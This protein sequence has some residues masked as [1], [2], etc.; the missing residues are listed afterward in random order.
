VQIKTLSIPDE[1]SFSLSA[2][3]GINTISTGKEFQTNQRFKSDYF[4]GETNSRTWFVGREAEQAAQSI[5]NAGNMNHYRF[6]KYTV[7]PLQNYA[8]SFGLPLQINPKHKIGLVA[9][10]TCRHEES[11]EDIKGINTIGLDTLTEN[12]GE[13]FNKNYKFVTSI[14]AIANIGWETANHSV[15]WRNLFNNRF[16]HSTLNRVMFKAY[17]MLD[18][19]LQLDIYTSPLQSRLLQT[20]IDGEHNLFRKQLKITWAADYNNISRI[21]PDDRFAQATIRSSSTMPD[22]NE[23]YII[24]WTDQLTTFMSSQ[25]VM[26]SR[27]NETKKNAGANA[28][29]TFTLLNN[30]QK[31]KAG[32]LHSERAADCEQ[33][34]LHAYIDAKHAQYPINSTSLVGFYDPDHFESGVPYYKFIGYNNRAIAY[35]KGNQSVDAFYIMGEFTPIAPLKIVGGVRLEDARTTVTTT[36]TGFNDNGS[37]FITKDSIV[38]RSAQDRLPSVTAIYSIT[39]ALNFRASYFESIAR[40]DFRE[41][42]SVKYY[43]V[44]SRGEVVNGRPL[45]QT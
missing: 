39:P 40:A 34:Y 8:L 33:A 1:K 11:R 17:E 14:G 19:N 24:D 3:S 38:T 20:Q 32:A 26:H 28:E 6:Y 37:L 10:A 7:T 2:G 42:T 41:L 44:A 45:E 23:N 22:P 16:T 4:F 35:Y 12:M 30:E 9:A 25:F 15:T 43:D 21:T 31:L 27:L 18:D 13:H 36:A 29:Y 5:T